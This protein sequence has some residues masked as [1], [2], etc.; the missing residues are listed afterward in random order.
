MAVPQYANLF[1]AMQSTCQAWCNAHGYSA[2]FCK[3]G[4]WWAFPPSGVMPIQI[5]TVMGPTSDRLVK[6][7]SLTLA[8]FPDGSLAHSSAEP[9]TEL[10]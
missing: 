6:I 10:K 2:P 1:E 3:D 8:L 5:K 7:G 4:E 9:S